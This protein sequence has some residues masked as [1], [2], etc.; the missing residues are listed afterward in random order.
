M[1]AL[2]PSQR[3]DLRAA[4]HPLHPVVAIGHHGLTPAV[5]HEIDVALLAH[6]LIKVRVFDD[7]RAAR[8]ALMARVCAEMQCAPVQH[9][10]KLLVLWRLNPEKH[11]AAATTAPVARPADRKAKRP[12]GAAAGGTG[13]AK[14]PGARSKVGQT[15]ASPRSARRLRDGEVRGDAAAPSPP[16][17]DQSRKRGRDALPEVPRAPQSRRRR[18]V[19]S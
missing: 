3:R 2:T 12:G 13:K 5:L 6:E 10:G 11:K 17:G 8:E 15:S 16:R 7:D 1:P 19:K 18:A 14:R 4:A 9:I